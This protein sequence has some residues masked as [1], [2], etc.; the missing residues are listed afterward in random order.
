MLSTVL[1][2][3]PRLLPVFIRSITRFR[4]RRYISPARL[5]FFLRGILPKGFHVLLG[6]LGWRVTSNPGHILFHV[7]LGLVLLL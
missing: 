6:G 3:N 4:F 5:L 1:T 2:S 7:H